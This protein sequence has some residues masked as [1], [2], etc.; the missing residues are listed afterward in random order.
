[1][2]L[3]VVLSVAMGIGFVVAGV[4]IG[5]VVGGGLIALGVTLPGLL[6]QDAWRLA[7]FA[8]GR[9]E[10]AFVN[11]AVWTLVLFPGFLVLGAIGLHSSLF[12]ILLLWGISGC[13][14]AVVGVAQS[15][16]LP[17]VTR[18]R[19]WWREHRDIGPRYLAAE[20]L[21]LVAAQG[22]V[23]VLGLV[24]GLA[25]AGSLRAAQLVLGPLNI[26]TMSVYFVV[27]PIGARMYAEHSPRLRSAAAGVSSLMVA[28]TVVL[29]VA[30]LAF[31]E[32][33][34][35]LLL[36][37]SWPGAELVFVPVAVAA[38]GKNVGYGARTGLLAM[39][40]ARRTLRLTAIESVLALAA[41]TIGAILAAASGAAWGLAF[42]T[43]AVALAWWREF[44][45]G[46]KVPAPARDATSPV[47]PPAARDSIA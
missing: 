7:F 12:A 45:A 4:V 33:L 40:M 47:A 39:A 43:C 36:G 1:M 17:D 31:P 16:V 27:V 28:A 14:A 22:V 20:L 29:S 8:A 35:P 21:P 23:F 30:I 19:S 11:D 42:V 5:G 41:G 13:V 18:A 6:M 26:L 34:G 15:R 10:A 46:L 32:G 38:I 44:G 37:E 24:A 2:G 25:A 9:G 3:V